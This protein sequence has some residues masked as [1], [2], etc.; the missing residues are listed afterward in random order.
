MRYF[1]TEKSGFAEAGARP[2]TQ[3]V[4]NGVSAARLLWW[5]GLIFSI[6]KRSLLNSALGHMRRISILAGVVLMSAVTLTAA[7]LGA[8]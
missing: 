5:R 4:A 8:A 2:R 6:E 1:L 7:L 3:V